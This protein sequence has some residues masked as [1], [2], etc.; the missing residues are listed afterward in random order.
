MDGVTPLLERL[1]SA[2][3]GDWSRNPAE[4]PVAWVRRLRGRELKP[5]LQESLEEFA[6]EYTRIR[7]RQGEQAGALT[8]LEERV[9]ELEK[10]LQNLEA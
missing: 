3:P 1:E 5:E 8:K 7:F 9:V 6:D 2:I 4:T 10:Q